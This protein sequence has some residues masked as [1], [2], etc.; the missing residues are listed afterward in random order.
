MERMNRLKI[1]TILAI[2]GCLP[3]FAAYKIVIDPY[4]ISAVLQNTATQ[5]LIEGSHNVRL[6]S[7][8]TKQ[9]KIRDY[10]S[11]MATIA[12]LYK[13]SLQNINGFGQESKY[14]VEIGLCSYEIIERVP[15]IIKAIKESKIS[16]KIMCVKELTD[17]SAK[18]QKL[19]MDFVNIVNNGKVQSPLKGNSEVK[20]DDGYNFLDRY[21]RL[22]LAN[23]IY[24]D[25]LAI[26]YKMELAELMARY[27][28]W[29]NL[30]MSVDPESWAAIMTGKNRVN[31]V[32]SMWK[33]LT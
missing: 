4:T 30:F 14:Y 2:L 17:L 3:T 9:E 1:L 13:T 32:I 12:E 25:L 18:T 10:T 20:K 27:A 15:R 5:S 19:V 6:D 31:M 29:D 11:T 16:G 28:S 33:G 22:V 7:I 24:T 26:K 21:D 8:K 23:R